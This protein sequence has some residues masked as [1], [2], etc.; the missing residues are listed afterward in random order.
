MN[1]RRISPPG[2]QEKI[3]EMFNDIYRTG[4]TGTFVDHAVMAKDGSIIILE[5]TISLMRSAQG[6]PTGFRGLS[7]NVTERL[8]AE[9]RLKE[10]ELRLRL[11]THNI[12]DIIWTVDFNLNF[13]Y[14]SPSIK[15]VLGFSSEEI[16]PIPVKAFMPPPKYQALEKLLSEELAK[17][18][19]GRQDRKGKA[20]IFEMEMLSKDGNAVWVEISAD[21]NRDESGNPFEILGVTRDISDRKK[22]EKALAESER[23]YR[24][25]TD[26]LRD[27]IW[28]MDFNLQYTYLSPSIELITGYTIE[29]I[30]QVPLPQQLTPASLALVEKVISE[31]FTSED[32]LLPRNPMRP[33]SLNWKSS[34]KTAACSGRRLWLLQPG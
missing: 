17:E 27:T 14:I 6:E 5:M 28:T 18:R 3:Y 34:V 7:R 21:F 2:S 26:N 12:H 4:E 20:V 16:I 29:E 1:Y 10:N 31:E 23:R 22:V 8:K 32:H 25:I 33:A 30:K 15:G 24:M 11:I 19:E 13:T 9:N